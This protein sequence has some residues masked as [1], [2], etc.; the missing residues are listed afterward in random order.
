MTDYYI[1][2]SLKEICHELQL[3]ESV[4]VDIVEYGIVCPEGSQPAEWYFDLDMIGLIRHAVRLH[5]DLDLAWQDVAIVSELLDK[6]NQ[7]QTE[8][9]LLKRR[10]DLFLQI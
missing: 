10:L 2:L 7:L 1:Q 4:C 3:S 9:E 8:N 6:R 5:R